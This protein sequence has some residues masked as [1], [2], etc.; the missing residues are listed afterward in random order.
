MALIIQDNTG[1]DT[2]TAAMSNFANIELL[3]FQHKM[4][5][6]LLSLEN[7]I[8]LYPGHSLIDEIYFK[9]AAIYIRIGEFEK[10]IEPLQKIDQYYSD[11]ILADDALMTMAKLYEEKLNKKEIAKELYESIIL[12]HS[13]SIFVDEARKRFRTLRGDFN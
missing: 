1:L 6:A 13:G 12:N 4:D 5:D 9:M 10:A 7:M 2:S 11:D 8:T 3:V